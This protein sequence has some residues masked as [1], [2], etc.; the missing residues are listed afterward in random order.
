[1]DA[2][3]TGDEIT[4]V[5]RP[6]DILL[7]HGHGAIS[8][9]IRRFDESDVDHAAFALDPETLVEAT[10]SGIRHVS[11]RRCLD[12]HVFTYVRRLAGDVDAE[13]ATRVART[14]E[15]ANRA[16]INE[17]VV[18]LA[19]LGLTRRLPI[20]EPSLRRLLLVLFD[21]AADMVTIMGREGRRILLSSDLVYRAYR[22]TGD[23]SLSLEIL[24][25]SEKPSPSPDRDRRLPL[26]DAVLVD[27]ASAR[28]D[29]VIDAGPSADLRDLG[30][31]VAL[32]ERELAGLIAAFERVDAPR[33][34]FM[35]DV[36]AD[37]THMAVVSD[38]ELHRAAIRFR[39]AVIT[40]SFASDLRSGGAA[41]H[42]WGLFRAVSSSV[43][44]GDLRY[45]PSLRTVTSL[46][47]QGRR[48]PHQ[49][50]RRPARDPID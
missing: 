46:R 16:A 50:I 42:P 12:E 5:V 30:E 36:V 35:P 32:A 27:W 47:P 40:L 11:V 14:I 38:D 25:P 7:F 8:W 20:E 39:D 49:L 24:F 13:P 28:P 3:R 21:R 48:T 2:Q 26:G 29:P 6:G 41:D 17:R 9:A 4:R 44:P 23:P 43:T 15:E 19:L 22:G 10:S 45:S 18:L 1:M 31:V 33:D 34:P 37:P